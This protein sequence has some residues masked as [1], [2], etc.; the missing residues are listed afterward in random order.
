MATKF[1][2][3]VES[4][5][6]DA[7]YACVVRPMAPEQRHTRRYVADRVQILRER[8]WNRAYQVHEQAWGPRRRW[9]GKFIRAYNVDELMFAT[10]TNMIPNLMQLLGYQGH[11]YINGPTI[12]VTVE[13]VAPSTQ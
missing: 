8:L 2:L 7:N 12:T 13:S 9:V 5:T 6:S 1:S 3:E 10:Q 4:E 11:A